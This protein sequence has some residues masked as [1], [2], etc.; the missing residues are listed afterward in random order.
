MRTLAG[1]AQATGQSG[2]QSLTGQQPPEDQPEQTLQWLGQ[3]CA[4]CA[5]VW[6]MMC[7]A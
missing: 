5:M 7:V 1:A 2:A 4:M 3:V 6:A